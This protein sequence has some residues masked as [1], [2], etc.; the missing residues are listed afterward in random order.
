MR[1][2]DASTDEIRRDIAQTRARIGETVEALGAQLNPSLLKQRVKDSVH[3][4]TIGKVQNMASETKDRVVNSGRGLVQVVRDNPIP[5]AMIAGG[6]G[7]L[8]F[9]RRSS[10]ERRPLE[11]RAVGA[12]V[13]LEEDEGSIT[14][15]DDVYNEHASPP[16]GTTSRAGSSV[17]GA[18]ESVAAGARSATERVASSTQDAARAVGRTAREQGA[19]VADSYEENPLILGAIAVA[20]GLAV[21]FAMPATQRESR[22][23]GMKRDELLDSVKEKASEAK[24]KVQSAVARTKSEV[25]S[26]ITDVAR[27][28]LGAI[29]GAQT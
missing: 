23:M 8:L 3:E 15:Y 18:A 25:Q 5:A 11:G 13:D 10:D 12:V 24:E 2:R 16:E 19:R 17:R 21:G 29:G 28:E 9:G 6:L 1:Q 27:E 22:L 4:A 20:A 7:W 14:T 26:T